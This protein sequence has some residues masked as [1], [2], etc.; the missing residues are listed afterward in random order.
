[1]AQISAD[2]RHEFH[3]AFKLFDQ[4]RQGTVKNEDVAKIMRCVGA[5]PTERQVLDL[6]D[7]F[8]GGANS[9]NFEQFLQVM[10]QQLLVPNSKLEV[11]ESFKI[12]DKD[13][14][15]LVSAA[16]LRHLMSNLGEPLSQDEVEELI[17]HADPH[18]TGQVDYQR[19]VEGLYVN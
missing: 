5:K 14:Q 17:A 18:G 15:G 10:G 7:Q 9:I 8:A 16:E 6:L 19:L 1:M 12:F 3:D 13:G 4:N 2:Q 11:A